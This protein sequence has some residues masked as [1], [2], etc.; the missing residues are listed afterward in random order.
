M[1]NTELGL[2]TVGEVTFVGK[3]GIKNIVEVKWR[4]VYDGETV[5]ALVEGENDTVTSCL[6]VLNVV[7]FSTEQ[8]CL[9]EIDRLGL[10]FTL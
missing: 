1:I 10:E 3:S 5:R 8:E 2:Q 4:L 6:S 9:D 7:E